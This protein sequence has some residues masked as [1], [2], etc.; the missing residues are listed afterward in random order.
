MRLGLIYCFTLA[1]FGEDSVSKLIREDA[2][3]AF[4]SN[5]M[6]RLAR[7]ETTIARLRKER[8]KSKPALLAW[9][10]ATKAYRAVRAY[11]AGKLP[12]FGRY[13]GQALLMF[14]EADEARGKNPDVSV[15]TITGSSLAVLADRLPEQYKKASWGTAYRAYRFIWKTQMQEVPKLPQH[16]KG[17]LLAGLAL[18]A[19]RTDRPEEVMLYLDRT[20]AM[21]PG[22]PYEAAAKQW[23]AD[24]A[25][26]TKVRLV[27]LSCHK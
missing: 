16:M 20:I 24:P 19:Q 6:V 27:C 22:T 10:A 17:E 9:E 21:L 12:E 26:A 3:A 23:K 4:Q 7:A 25:A 14:A 5:D 2:F 11:E 18:V 8:P 13:Y 1:A 15:A